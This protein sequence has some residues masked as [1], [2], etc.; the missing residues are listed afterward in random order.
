MNKVTI[1]IFGNLV[2]AVGIDD[3]YVADPRDGA[4]LPNQLLA[5]QLIGTP[6]VVDN[7]CYR[8]TRDGVAFVVGQLEVLR[9]FLLG[10]KIVENL[11]VRGAECKV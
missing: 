2:T 11:C 3:R 8:L 9:L 1:D 5:V 7:F 4:A 6:E 10:K